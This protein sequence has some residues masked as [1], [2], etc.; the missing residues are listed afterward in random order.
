MKIVRG[1][2]L[3]ILAVVLAGTALGQNKSNSAKR[4]D[5]LKKPLT[6]ESQGSF[7]IGGESKALGAP[8]ARGFGSGDVTV[9]QMYVQYQIPQRGD[10]HVARA[11]DGTRRE[12]RKPSVGDRALSCAVLR[13][14]P[15]SPH[16][17]RRRPA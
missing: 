16:P 12:T 2:S 10:Q 17:R 6:I 8:G 11:A 1:K 7:F 15:R 4:R 14:T 13:R 9:N 3:V 5:D